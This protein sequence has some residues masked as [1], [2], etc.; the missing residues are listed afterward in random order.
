MVGIFDDRNLVG[1]L[2][3]GFS[4]CRIEHCGACR[5]PAV[6]N[7]PPGLA[8]LFKRTYALDPYPGNYIYTFRRTFCYKK[9]NYFLFIRL[10]RQCPSSALLQKAQRLYRFDFRLC[11]E[12]EPK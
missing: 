11:T 4:R 12:K 8:Y 6:H 1:G 3:R 10:W 5:Q 7:D 9:L 2:V